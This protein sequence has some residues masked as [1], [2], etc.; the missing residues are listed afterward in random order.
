MSFFPTMFI[1]CENSLSA[2]EHAYNVSCAITKFSFVKQDSI[3]CTG[4]G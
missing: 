1:S 4:Y 3:Y 2:L